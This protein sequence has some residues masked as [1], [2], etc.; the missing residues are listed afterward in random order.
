MLITRPRALNSAA[1]A[2]LLPILLVIVFAMHLSSVPEF[3]DFRL[4]ARRQLS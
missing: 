4:L 3:L 1:L 2:L